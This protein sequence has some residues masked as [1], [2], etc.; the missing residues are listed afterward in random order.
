[1]GHSGTSV[2]E[3]VYR[4]WT[5]RELRHSFVS[6][7]SASGTRIE[8]ISDLEVIVHQP[9]L[10]TTRGTS[11]RGPGARTHITHGSQSERKTG[12]LRKEVIRAGG[13]LR[14]S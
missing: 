7:L 11:G 1:M 6:I 5:P 8:D 14:A 9:L 12:N 13:R 2:T 4:D 10:L 3:T